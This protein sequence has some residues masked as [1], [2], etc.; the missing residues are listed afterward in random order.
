MPTCPCVFLLVERFV[1]EFLDK[2][3]DVSVSKADVMHPRTGFT[4]AEVTYVHL[5]KSWV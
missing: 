2:H 3:R 4:E 1:G 5:I